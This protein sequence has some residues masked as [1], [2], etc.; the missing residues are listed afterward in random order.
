VSIRKLKGAELC[1]M[2]REKKPRRMS[3]AV[4]AVE[5]RR[6]VVRGGGTN[7][8]RGKKRQTRISRKIGNLISELVTKAGFISVCRRRPPSAASHFK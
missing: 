2:S 5:K 6:R 3:L 1:E 7:Q 8:D 4:E